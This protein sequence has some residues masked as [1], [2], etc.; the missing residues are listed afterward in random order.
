MRSKG[1]A[2]LLMPAG[3]GIDSQPLN[4]ILD[5]C[6]CTR[7]HTTGLGIVTAN[8]VQRVVW[9]ISEAAYGDQ[10]ASLQLF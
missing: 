7:V 1:R 8:T 10:H 6:L 4:S 2:V 5:V 3:F 9:A